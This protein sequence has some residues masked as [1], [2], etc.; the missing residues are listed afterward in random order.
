MPVYGLSLELSSAETNLYI[1][2]CSNSRLI[3]NL[4]LQAFFSSVHPPS[5]LTCCVGETPDEWDLYP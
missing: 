1:N 3:T 2:I 5:T 4:L